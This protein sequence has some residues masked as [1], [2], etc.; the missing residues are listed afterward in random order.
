[1]T[2]PP[3]GM[4]DMA[5]KEH[6][7]ILRQGV[8]AWNRWREE[9][10]EVKP[11]LSGAKLN[12]ADLSGANLFEAK[13]IRADLSEADLSEAKLAR[14]NLSKA[15]LSEA[16]LT[17]SNLGFANLCQTELNNAVLWRADLTYAVFCG[18]NL[19]DADLTQTALV[20]TSLEGAILNGCHV[21][22]ISVWDVAVD[23]NTRQEG[24]VITPEDEPEITVDNLEVAQFIYLLL[25]NEKLRH[26]IDTITSKVVLILGRFAP[27]RKA[28]LDLIREEVRKYDLL[29]VMFDFDPPRSMSLMQTVTTLARMSRLVIADITDAKSVIGELEATVKELPRVV[30]LPLLCEGAKPWGMFRDLAD[31]PWVLP[32]KRYSDAEDMRK[33]VP[34]LIEEAEQHALALKENR[35]AREKE[36]SG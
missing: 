24:L 12:G 33:S 3:N 18:A 25:N 9:N 29:P 34:K 14:A 23:E 31:Y 6:L 2:L 28:I 36:F 19:K 20:E 8:D 22:G 10:P 35:E 17:G 7:A 26:V 1:M 21:Y 4:N 13:L 30:F 5:N 15:N 16:K 11:D 27:E 32:T